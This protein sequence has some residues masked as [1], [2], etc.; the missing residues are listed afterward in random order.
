MRFALGSHIDH[1]EIIEELGEGAYAETYLARDT[2]VDRLVV[3]KAPNPQLLADP[4]IFQR[5]RREAEIARSLDHPGVQRALDAG[6]SRTEQYLVLEYIKGEN[7]RRRTRE[8]GAPRQQLSIELVLRWGEQL[9]SVLDYLHGHGIVHRDLKPENILVDTDDDLKVADFGTA[10]LDGAKRLTWKHLNDGL[11]TPDYM[12]P[13]Q[14][15]G[16]RGDHRSDIYAWGILMYEMLTGTVPFRGDNWMATM[17]GHLTK[18]PEPVGHARKDCPPG[19]AA[20]VMHAMRRDPDHRYQDATDLLAD[21]ARYDT[22]DP[23]TYDLAPE[24]AIG[25]LAAAGSAKRMWLLAGAISLGFVAVCAII[26]V[27]SVVLR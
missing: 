15:Q 27:L 2:V 16:E 19:L 7:M 9:A 22:L 21:L 17:A 24:P 25:G 8:L 14:I 26:V 4:A 20:I 10:L 5:Y 13:E 1:Y 12:S 23:N 18:T 3:L 6:E 11:G